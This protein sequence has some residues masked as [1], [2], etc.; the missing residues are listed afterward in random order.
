[1]NFVDTH[2]LFSNGALRV[3]ILVYWV[4][5]PGVIYSWIFTRKRNAAGKAAVTYGAGSSF[6]FFTQ[7]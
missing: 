3:P 4:L 6:G 2:A 5:K 1:M 7:V